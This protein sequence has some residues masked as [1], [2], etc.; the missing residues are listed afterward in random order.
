LKSGGAAQQRA[1]GLYYPLEETIKIDHPFYLTAQTALAY[2]RRSGFDMLAVDY[3]VDHLHVGY[4]RGPG[5]AEP[6]FT[7]APDS[8]ERQWHELRAIQ[9][10]L[11]VSPI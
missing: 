9:N 6:G 11:P 10:L 2:L 1:D 7:P 3:A 5:I 4:L 8:V